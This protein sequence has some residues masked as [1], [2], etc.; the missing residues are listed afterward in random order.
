[1]NSEVNGLFAYQALPCSLQ[2]SRITG[3]VLY[4]SRKYAAQSAAIPA[5]LR[6]GDCVNT[7]VHQVD[8]HFRYSEHPIVLI[9]GDSGTALLPKKYGRRSELSEKTRHVRHLRGHVLISDR[10]RCVA[11]VNPWARNNNNDTMTPTNAKPWKITPAR[12]IQSLVDSAT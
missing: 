6:T 4:T 7:F 12:K 5:R 9:A 11:Y 10:K 2:N 1:M 3:L 8:V